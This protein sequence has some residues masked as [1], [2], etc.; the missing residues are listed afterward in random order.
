MDQ[1]SEDREINKKRNY[2]IYLDRE[3]KKH[4]SGQVIRRITSSFLDQ[5][6]KERL[7]LLQDRS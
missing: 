4:S 1:S 5:S 6:K 7:L 3:R 2:P